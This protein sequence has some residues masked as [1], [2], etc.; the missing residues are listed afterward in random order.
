VGGAHPTFLSRVG[1]A[2]EDRRLPAGAAGLGRRE[3]WGGLGKI[4]CRAAA[5]QG[6]YGAKIKPAEKLY[7]PERLGKEGRRR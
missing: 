1:A 7:Y 6:R 3:I 2:C 5:R 4:S